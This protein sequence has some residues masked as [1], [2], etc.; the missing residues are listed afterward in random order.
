[1]AIIEQFTIYLAFF[2]IYNRGK[3]FCFENVLLTIICAGGFCVHQTH[4]YLF[5]LF[6]FHLLFLYFCA[7]K[8]GTDRE[9]FTLASDLKNKSFLFRLAEGN[10]TIIIKALRKEQKHNTMR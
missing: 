4:Y 10:S 3:S 5:Y 7:Q 8:L 6:I 1:M 2:S 9:Y